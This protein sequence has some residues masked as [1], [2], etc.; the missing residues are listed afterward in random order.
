MEEDFIPNQGYV[1]FAIKSDVLTIEACTQML[2]MKPRYQREFS[3]SFPVYWEIGTRVI[4]D[5]Y[6]YHIIRNIV[7][8]LLP[9]KDRLIALKQQYPELHYVLEIVL[10]KGEGTP[11]LSLENDTLSFL[12]EIGAILDCDIYRR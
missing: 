5:P 2:G 1:Y 10:F 6:L 12:G 4:E 9:I 11:A 3:D 8:E 7:A